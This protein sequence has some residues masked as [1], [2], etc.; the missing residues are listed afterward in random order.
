MRRFEMLGLPGSGKTKL[1]GMLPPELGV[2]RLRGF[3]ERDRFRERQQRT[4]RIAQRLLPRAVTRR[5]L[6]ASTPSATDAV[7]FLL[8]N[9]AFHEAAMSICDAIHDSDKRETAVALLYETYAQYGLAN[10]LARPGDGFVPEEGVWQILTY[11]LA[12]AGPDAT[13]LLERLMEH[14]PSLDGLIVLDLD[15]DLAVERVETRAQTSAGTDVRNFAET[16]LMPGMGSLIEPISQFLRTAGVPVT[17]IRTDQPAEEAL[18]ELI[19][20]L[21]EHIER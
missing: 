12:H 9:R 18:E 4:A 20:F 7:W 21:S 11:A 10:R 8:R 5:I 13:A 2:M 15:M 17:V 19:A 6:T 1:A 16:E 14:P 3:V